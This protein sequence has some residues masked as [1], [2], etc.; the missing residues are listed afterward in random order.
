MNLKKTSNVSKRVLLT[1]KIPGNGHCYGAQ[2]IVPVDRKLTGQKHQ[3]WPQLTTLQDRLAGLRAPK[4]HFLSWMPSRNH[5][6]VIRGFT[7]ASVKLFLVRFFQLSFSFFLLSFLMISAP[8]FFKCVIP[9]PI[10]VLR[11]I[12]ECQTRCFTSTAFTMG[13]EEKKKLR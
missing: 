5:A 6:F 13:K 9:S 4:R 7:L 2:S 8:Y 3:S 1:G 11:L 12:L 10:V